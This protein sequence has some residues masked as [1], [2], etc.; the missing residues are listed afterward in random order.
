MILVWKY[1]VR[2]R[3]IRRYFYLLSLLKDAIQCKLLNI[4]FHKINGYVKSQDG[5]LYLPIILSE[6]KDKGV[7]ICF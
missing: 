7:L 3:T 1:Y 5:S 2:W 6:E 4:I